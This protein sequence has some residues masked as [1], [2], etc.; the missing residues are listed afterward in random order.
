MGATL[1]V[2]PAAVGSLPGADAY[3]AMFDLILAG[4]TAA[5]KE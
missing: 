2:L 4:L 5:A 1:V 3:P